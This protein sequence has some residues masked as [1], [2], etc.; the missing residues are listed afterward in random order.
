VRIITDVDD[1]ARLRPGEVLVCRTTDPA[2]TVL[3]GVAAALITDGGG[4]LSHAAIVAREYAIPAVVGT[5][6]ATSTLADG[7][8]VTVDGTAG[9]ITIDGRLGG[10]GG[11]LS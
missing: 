7:Q 5:G 11:S 10:R 8:V 4:V 2:W 9:S 6:A 1:V 3:F